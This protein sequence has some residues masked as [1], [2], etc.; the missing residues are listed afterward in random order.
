MAVWIGKQLYLPL[1]VMNWITLIELH[2]F[3]FGG[4]SALLLCGIRAIH[5]ICICSPWVK[6]WRKRLTRTPD[7]GGSSRSVLGSL[8]GYWRQHTMIT[9]SCFKSAIVAGMCTFWQVFWH[10]ESERSPSCSSS[11]SGP[12]VVWLSVQHHWSLRWYVHGHK[13]NDVFLAISWILTADLFNI[14]GWLLYA[15]FK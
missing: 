6:M 11:M 9:Q 4:R 3:W 1:Q 15:S 10:W 7:V 2:M 13:G 8:V 5:A 14:C 12:A